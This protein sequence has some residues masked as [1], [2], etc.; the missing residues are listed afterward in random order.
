MAS[1]LAL[2]TC[3]ACDTEVMHSGCRMGYC[4]AC[5]PENDDNR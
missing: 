5:C 3:N 1:W 2:E 4:W